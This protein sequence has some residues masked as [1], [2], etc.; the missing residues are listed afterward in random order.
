MVSVGE[1]TGA[2]GLLAHP[3]G[4][5]SVVERV[6]PSA[7][8][9]S[10]SATPASWAQP[11]RRRSGEDRVADAASTGD[12]HRVLHPRSLRRHERGGEA[13]HTVVRALHRRHLRGVEHVFAPRRSDQ[14][15][16]RVRD[17]PPRARAGTRPQH[18]AA[19]RRDASHQP[20]R[21]PGIRAGGAAAQSARNRV[22]AMR[23]PAAPVITVTDAPLAAAP[24]PTCSW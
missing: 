10:A 3:L 8:R 15:E 21:P 6:A 24:Q 9:S 12:R 17:A 13:Q 14:G 4:G 11:V 23:P 19:R 16:A 20:R 1:V 2:N 7:S 5:L 22:A 18:P